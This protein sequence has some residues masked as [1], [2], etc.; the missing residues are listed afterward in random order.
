M[1]FYWLF[2]RHLDFGFV[3]FDLYLALN[4]HFVFALLNHLH[5]NIIYFNWLHLLADFPF[6][7]DVFLEL[8]ASNERGL[9]CVGPR[10][11]AFVVTN[12]LQLLGFPVI[13]GL[14]LVAALDLYRLQRNSFRGLGIRI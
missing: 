4:Y 3:G 6:Y 14:C 7:L 8:G 13:I 12:W 9:V 10:T 2:L 11:F 5:P 1:L